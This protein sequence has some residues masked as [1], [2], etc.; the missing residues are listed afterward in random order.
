MWYNGTMS[1]PKQ[2]IHFWPNLRSEPATAS[3]GYTWGKPT[4]SSNIVRELKQLGYTE[5]QL[6]L[7]PETIVAERWLVSDDRA[8]GSKVLDP[9]SGQVTGA[10]YELLEKHGAE[11]VGEQHFQ[12][13]GPY[14]GS[15]MKQ[16]DT[17][18]EPQKGSLSVQVHPK[19]GHP[20]RPAKPEMWQGEGQVYLGWKHDVTEDEIRAAYEAGK[21]EELLQ[22]I[23][24]TPEKLVRVKGGMIHAIRYG[25][26]TAEWSMA[27]GAEDIKK[28]N[29]KDATV[30]PYDRTDGKTPRPGKEDLEGTLALL[31]EYEDG[32][33]A[34]PEA[35]LFTQPELLSA[36]EAGNTLT[37]LFTTPEV[38][39]HQY[40]I[41][42][43]MKLDVSRRGFPLYV[44][45][46]TIEVLTADGTLGI[47]QA[48]KEVF[49]PAVLGAIT[50]KAQE[51]TPAILQQWYTPL[52][53]EKGE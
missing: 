6:E 9:K 24:L 33:V 38:W 5:H 8:L 37:R 7:E 31:R 17:N 12:E 34:V 36:D 52:R 4:H 46:G 45:K 14:L 1:L 43:Q 27:P 44:K 13:Y 49:V 28:G 30:S 2:L 41:T 3:T 25:T 39:V 11:L 51:G 48:G 20:T 29:L 21:L 15:I 35:E 26:F 50:V 47:L 53:T 22:E 10:F 16:L 32:F 42:T 19:P 40:Q 23:S 18:D